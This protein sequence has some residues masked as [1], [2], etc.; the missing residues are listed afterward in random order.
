MNPGSIKRIRC[1]RSVFWFKDYKMA[2]LVPDVIN[3][4]CCNSHIWIHTVK[5]FKIWQWMADLALVL[6]YTLYVSYT[7][8]CM[9]F[10][11]KLEYFINIFIYINMYTYNGKYLT[12]YVDNFLR[13]C[14]YKI[15]PLRNLILSLTFSLCDW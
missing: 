11:H 3:E 15:S 2:E 12:K 14:S 7:N 8:I 6:N 4:C 9:L 1:H 10:R 13:Y 5:I